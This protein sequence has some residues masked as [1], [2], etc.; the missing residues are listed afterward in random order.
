MIN[1][2]MSLVKD[3]QYY[4]RFP[5]MKESLWEKWERIL[6]EVVDKLIG[7]TS[8]LAATILLASSQPVGAQSDNIN[9]MTWCYLS[10]D[11]Y[12]SIICNEDIL[13]MWKVPE[14]RKQDVLLSWYRDYFEFPSDIERVITWVVDAESMPDDFFVNAIKVIQDPNFDTLHLQLLS[15]VYRNAP[16]YSVSTKEQQEAFREVRDELEEHIGGLGI[17]LPYPETEA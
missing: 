13:S 4:S 16:F 15:D 6:S 11:D 2:Y 17:Q 5:Y 10:E 14:G 7:N 1:I 12:E 9:S 8:F 3:S